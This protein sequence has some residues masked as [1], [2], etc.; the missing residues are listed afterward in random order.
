MSRRKITEALACALFLVE[1]LAIIY[2]VPL[3]IGAPP[4]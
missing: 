2:A 1:L 4:P 3:L